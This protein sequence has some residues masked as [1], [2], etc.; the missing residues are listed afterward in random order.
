MQQLH[1][2]KP[3]AATSSRLCLPKALFL[4]LRCRADSR[5]GRLYFI[6][7]AAMSFITHTHI[8]LRGGCLCVCDILYTIIIQD[9][10]GCDASCASCRILN[11]A[12]ALQLTPRTL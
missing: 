4:L 3:S 7:H 2:I 1:L 12:R 8:V 11:K 5:L 6:T 10:D 9:E